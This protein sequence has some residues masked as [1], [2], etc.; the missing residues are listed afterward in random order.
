ML[1]LDNPRIVQQVHDAYLEICKDLERYLASEW[2][3]DEICITKISRLRFKS[4]GVKIGME[5]FVEPEQA[6]KCVC[7]L[8]GGSALA[9]YLN[10]I[11][12]YLNSIPL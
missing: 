11:D 9:R 5:C 3:L 2:S 1:E 10:V 12:P 8:V 6:L 4:D 7:E